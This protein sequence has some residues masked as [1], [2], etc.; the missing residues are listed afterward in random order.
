MMKA[1]AADQHERRRIGDANARPPA[2]V[3]AI[4]QAEEL[5]APEEAVESR[6]FLHIMAKLMQGRPAGAET[7][8]L[9]TIRADGAASLFQT[10]A[11]LGLE[12]PETLPLLPLP[13]TSYRDVIMRPLDILA[14]RGQR[15]TIDVALADRLVAD[16]KGADALPLLAF[17]LS[18]LYQEFAPKGRIGFAEYKAVGEI[19]GSIDLALKQALAKPADDPAIPPGKEEQLTLLRSTFIPWLARIDPEGGEPMRR[20]A[21]LHGLPERNLAMVRRL[22]RARL[23]V[24]DRQSGAD[25]AEVAHESLLRQWP[26]LSGWLKEESEGLK[27]LEEVKLAASKWVGNG[28]LDIW[29]DHRAE[30]L[31]LAEALA[32]RDD[33]RRLLD[34]DGVEYL[35]ACRNR[36]CRAFRLEGSDLLPLG[37]DRAGLGA[38][39]YAWPPP[40]EPTRPP[41]RGLRS[42]EADDAGVFFGRDADVLRG[43]ERVRR[44]I[45]T[46]SA[47]LLIILGSSGVGKSSFLQ[48]GLW[49][50]LA[51]QPAEFVALPVVRV[52][53][54]LHRVLAAALATAFDHLGNPRDP[55]EIRASL[56][57]GAS[58]FFAL[59]G[60]LVRLTKRELKVE[61]SDPT[62]ILS[63]DQ[64]DQLF[65]RRDSPE[66][67]NLL[68]DIL[69]EA[70]AADRRVLMI[71][72]V[73]SDSYQLLE[74]D[75]VF[76]SARQDLFNLPP[77]G[78][79]QLRDVIARPAAR[80]SAQFEPPTLSLRLAADAARENALPLLAYLLE[81]IWLTRAASGDGILRLQHEL[82]GILEI[83]AER[84]ETFV[85]EHAESIDKLRRLFVF[86]LAAVDPDGQ[87]R[88]RLCRLTDLA[89]AERQLVMELAADPYRLVVIS[90]AQATGEVTAEVAHEAIFH[91]WGR[92]RGWMA[93]EREF[94]AWRNDV[95]RAQRA[96]E[97]AS[98]ESRDSALLAGFALDQARGWLPEHAEFLSSQERE[99]IDHSIRLADFRLREAR[100]V[101]LRIR[102]TTV[103]AAVLILILGAGVIGWVNQDYL[104]QRYRDF[105]V[106]RPYLQAQVLPFVLSPAAERSLSPGDAFSEC[107]RACPVMIVLSAGEFVMG[108][109]APEPGRFPNEGPQHVVRIERPFAVSKFDVTFD[110]WDACA[111]Y[112]DCDH[113][114]NDAGF[115]RGTRPVINVTWEDAKT[116]V[117]WLSKV[118][119]RPYRLLSEAEYEYAA[120]GGSAT[121]FPWGEDLGT[122]NAN[123]DGCGSQWDGQKSAP[124]GSFPANRFGLYD[125][126]GNIGKWVEDCDH[127]DYV[128]APVDGSAWIIGG[129]CSRR[130]VRG[131]SWISAPRSIR[132]ASRD[133]RPFTGRNS[134]VGFRIARTLSP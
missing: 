77:L 1:I 33:F 98:P 116:Y 32:A 106:S 94:L 9:F 44:L 108:S 110:D 45:E 113:S 79:D 13:Q 52:T 125:M 117:A 55:D 24:L 40:R 75:A 43:L 69:R 59:A 64:A 124:T 68:A 38:A 18:H 48:A 131:G 72:T 54:D 126:V 120:R 39:S 105:F 27:L 7:L 37:L 67:R 129:E 26:T 10:I 128:G 50:R 3:L 61:E 88:R 107:A 73:R 19:A 14:R 80:C 93:E 100:L 35:R 101:R 15:L 112:G 132:S 104:Q 21:R 81:N 91:G 123:C 16:S 28:R 63:L 47:K 119:G 127:E 36:E 22:V 86:S 53:D 11:D 56:A 78:E 87:V 60:D 111:A 102:R 71:L 49:P 4:D 41:Y 20:T 51:Q 8:V 133:F 130:V 99:F 58:G 90:A 23:L 66:I 89:L 103:A 74:S 70:E 31:Y 122:A 5:F 76:S 96:W 84:A 109:P 6:L 30:R 57:A 12:L 85:A 115:G 34:E 114:V 82:G 17:T 92:L 134:F 42:L 97:M 83:V 95:Q 118:S 2:L 29:I 121:A 25:V 46:R 65:V 62:V